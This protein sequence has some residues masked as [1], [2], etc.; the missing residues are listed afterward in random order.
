MSD[1]VRHGLH[2]GQRVG[3]LL[4]LGEQNLNV[5]LLLG[6]HLDQEHRVLH[7]LYV[8]TIRHILHIMELSCD[9]G[10]LLGGPSE[11]LIEVVVA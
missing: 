6:H 10:L 9:H 5:L 3:Q 11:I 2:L 1:H 7:L 8:L 4:L